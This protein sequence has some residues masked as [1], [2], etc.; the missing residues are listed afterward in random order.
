MPR[1]YSSPYPAADIPSNESFWQFVQRHNVD[2]AV[3]DTVILQEHERPEKTFTY[4]SVRTMAGLGA[5]ALQ[6]VLGLRRGDTLLMVGK[7]SLDYLNV[8]FSAL[9][10]GVTAALGSPTA[11][12]TDLVHF[13]ETVSPQA[14]F[15]DAGEIMDKMTKAVSMSKHCQATKPAL[16]GIS[17]RGTSSLS[18]SGACLN[19][20]VSFQGAQH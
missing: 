15:C 11:T 17:R 9:W 18:V 2:D 8:E 20:T 12:A 6:S 5:D 19:R 13:I 7:N 3:P 16:V 14:I 4:G 1:I 10:M